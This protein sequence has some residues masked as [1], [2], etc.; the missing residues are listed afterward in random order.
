MKN[1]DRLPL[2]SR[3][4]VL[5]VVTAFQLLTGVCA[6]SAEPLPR[7]PVILISVDTLR[8]DHLSCYGY[9]RLVTPNIDKLTKGGTLFTQINSQVPLTLPSHAS[10]FT[11]TYPF[12]NSVEDNGEILPPKATTLAT[13]LKSRGYRTAAFVGGFVLDRRFGLDQ[14]FDLYDSPFDL[15]RE[16]WIDPEELK[17]PAEQ[18]IGAAIRWLDQNSSSPFF[19]FLHLYDLHAPYSLPQSLRARF[20]NDGYDAELWY[21]DKSLGRFWTFLSEK[22]LLE[23]TLIVFLSDHG[24]GLREHGESSHGFFI[25][26]STLHVPL[27]IHWPVGAEHFQPQ[28]DK[29]AGLIDVAPTICEFLGEPTPPEFQGQSLL[30]L[31]RGNSRSGPREVYSESLYAHIHYGCSALFALRVGRFIYIE[32]PSPELYGLV[33]DPREVHNLYASQESTALD[34]HKR[35]FSLRRHFGGGREIQARKLSPEVIERLNSLGYVAVSNPRPV[36]LESGPDPKDRIASYEET[37]R[38]IALAYSGR[39]RQSAN[40]LETVLTGHPNM[41]GARNIL[42]MVQQKLGEQKEAIRSFD[43]VLQADPENLLAR[44]NL[45][46]SYS[47]LGQLG[48]ASRELQGVLAFAQG[49]NRAAEQITI[50]AEELLGNI[51]LKQKDYERA[52]AQ[53][54]HLLTLAPDDFVA[55]YNLAWLAAQ[56]GK[57]DE[58]IRQ[59]R[60][61]LRAYPQN[62]EA[63]NALGSLYLRQGSL[64]QARSEFSAAIRENPKFAWAHYNLG[65]TLSRKKMYEEAAQEFRKALELDPRLEGAREALSRLEAMKN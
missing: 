44:F 60:E 40:L 49:S 26:Q 28:V 10:L 3:L 59:L 61:A 38:A 35:L 32:A 1:T 4:A 7:T 14:G 17:R 15:R 48:E 5:W 41:P 25:Y 63:H 18:V 43:S 16:Q 42:G 30:E 55:H 2:A 24:E 33:G 6:F 65:L 27:I 46:V 36:A 56:E 58:G 12:W 23:K 39:L 53:F 31:A 50:P 8:A 45:A 34:L 20:G 52:R 62:A 19:V 29:P 22:G 54:T 51:F 64:D 37:R 9:Q 57:L 13:I 11:S 21:V 47:M